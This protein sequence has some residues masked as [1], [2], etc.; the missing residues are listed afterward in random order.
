MTKHTIEDIDN[1]IIHC[2]PN[3]NI[4]D[5]MQDGF[6]WGCNRSSWIKIC[7]ENL[8]MKGISHDENEHT[9]VIFD[10]MTLLNTKGV[11]VESC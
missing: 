3:K 7:I 5:I 2:A 4:K 9:K 6:S 11:I 10:A 1:A 8:W